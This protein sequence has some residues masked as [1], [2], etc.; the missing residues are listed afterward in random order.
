M[1]TLLLDAV[2]ACLSARPT[3]LVTWLH[4]R[5]VTSGVVRSVH[6]HALVQ[7]LVTLAVVRVV[8]VP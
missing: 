1:F 6:T 4:A 3:L 7:W 5:A 8:G 2:L